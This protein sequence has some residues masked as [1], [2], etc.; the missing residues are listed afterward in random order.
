MAEVITAEVITAGVITWNRRLQRRALP[1]DPG[2]PGPAGRHGATGPRPGSFGARGRTTF[3]GSAL[4]CLRT[5]SGNLHA[6]GAKV[7]LLPRQKAQPWRELDL[8]RSS[9]ARSPSNR[10][11]SLHV[12]RPVA[13]G[14]HAWTLRRAEQAA[15]PGRQS[16]QEFLLPK[17][18]P[19][20]FPHWSTS[21]EPSPDL[22]SPPPPPYLSL[23]HLTEHRAIKSTRPGPCTVALSGGTTALSWPRL[24]TEVDHLGQ[25]R[26]A[27]P[28]R[29]E[30]S[31]L[32]HRRGDDRTAGG[33]G[34]WRRCPG[35]PREAGRQER[36]S[37]VTWPRGR[38]PGAPGPASFLRR[39][40]SKVTLATRPPERAH[41]P[42]APAHPA[43]GCDVAP[44]I[45][46]LVR[47]QPRSTPSRQ[48]TVTGRP[49]LRAYVTMSPVPPRP[50]AGLPS[51]TASSRS[52]WSAMYA[53][54][55]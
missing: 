23:R 27:R 14:S 13:P 53:P 5:R 6:C 28:S 32:P 26:H 15:P 47:G 42:D 7:I 18:R 17:A 1:T 50:R 12:Q 11:G 49:R 48:I 22:N 21:C 54:A 20:P 30:R 24:A 2:H 29:T 51:H 41:R 44:V 4:A 55:A 34:R 46:D 19:A 16:P 52:Q 40:Q 36:R 10:P 25:E 35:R 3:G 8:H 38:P 39:P 31:R 45:R 9:R 43:T 37:G 33:S